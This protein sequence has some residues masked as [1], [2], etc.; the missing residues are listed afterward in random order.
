MRKNEFNGEFDAMEKK[1]QKEQQEK[2]EQAELMAYLKSEKEKAEHIVNEKRH[3]E[4]P[5]YK[6]V[7]DVTDEVAHEQIIKGSQKYKEPFNPASWT[8]KELVWHQ[9]QELRDAQVYGVGLL[10]RLTEQEEQI[11]GLKQ[12]LENETCTIIKNRELRKE[13]DIAKAEAEY[14]RQRLLKEV[15]ANGSVIDERV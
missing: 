12:E 9:L 7:D 15:G 1:E 3:L 6:K 13:I 10:E 8:N 14:W 11:E 4:H 5:F 2:K